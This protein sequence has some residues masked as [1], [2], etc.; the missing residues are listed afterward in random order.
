MNNLVTFKATFDS[1]FDGNSTHYND[2]S[3]M[4]AAGGF[5]FGFSNFLKS[6]KT[7]SD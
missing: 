5:H 3:N 2:P 1:N 7:A 6:A 4:F